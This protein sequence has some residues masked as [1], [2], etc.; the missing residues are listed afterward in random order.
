MPFSA[1]DLSWWGWLLCSTVASL[2]CLAS[3]KYA[4]KQFSLWGWLVA[5]L[6]GLVGLFCGVIG[7]VRFIKWIW[8]S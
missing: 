2:V 4:D 3:V 7:A 1:S 8:E 6:T 5:L